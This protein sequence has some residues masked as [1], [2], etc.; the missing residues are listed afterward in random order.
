MQENAVFV[1]HFQTIGIDLIARKR[2]FAFFGFALLS[3]TGPNIRIK[4]IG[5]LAS[6]QRVRANRHLASTCGGVFNSPC[7]VNGVRLVAV[8]AGNG[9][10][11][12][13]F[14]TTNHQRMRHIVAVA[15]KCELQSLKSSFLFI[16]RQQIR[17]NL[18]GMEFIRK[19]VDNRDRTKLRQF[20]QIALLKRAD[21]DAV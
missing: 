21:H 5:I 14:G 19:A 15:D 18:T 16:N 7:R 1:S 3:H 11:H 6:F 20:L 10:V 9:D 12:A 4:H 8:R 17:Q 13:E 2:L